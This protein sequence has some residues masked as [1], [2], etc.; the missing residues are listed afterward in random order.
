MS[1]EPRASCV[2]TRPRTSIQV[3]SV[4]P[5]ECFSHA[6][7]V[8]KTPEFHIMAVAQHAHLAATAV[9]GEAFNVRSRT[10]TVFGAQPDF[11]AS[12]TR[13]SWKHLAEPIRVTAD[14]A[15]KVSR[16]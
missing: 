15:L 6:S 4:C 8:A 14:D 12:R 9:F 5:G 3:S 16:T 11:Q 7:Q 13:V 10:R 2:C 1:C